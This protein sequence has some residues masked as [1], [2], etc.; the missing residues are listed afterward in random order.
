MPWQ[1]P[2]ALAERARP[3]GELAAGDQDLGQLRV[4]RVGA[5]QG[6]HD[7][8][9][10]VA[11]LHAD[12]PGLHLERPARV[13]RPIGRLVSAN[14]LVEHDPA[15]P[16]GQPRRVVEQLRPA[17]EGV[18]VPGEAVARAEVPARLAVQRLRPA[19]VRVADI[20]RSWAALRLQSSAN[21]S[22][23][24]RSIIAAAASIVPG[25]PQRSSFV[26]FPTLAAIS[27]VRRSAVSGDGWRSHAT[28][29]IPARPSE[30]RRW[31]RPGLRRDVRGDAGPVPR[32]GVDA[33]PRQPVERP[34][35]P[36]AAQVERQELV[37]RDLAVE[38]VGRPQALCV[39]RGLG[40][41]ADRR[42]R[43]ARPAGVPLRAGELLVQLGRPEG[44]R[45][46]VRPCARR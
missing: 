37:G 25:L 1:R 14:C 17:E 42:D 2:A 3:P 16:G 24:P 36:G 19:A 29:R 45:R 41:A 6:G 44:V 8:G 43:V 31:Q 15:E 20:D 27:R 26:S 40:V 22:S 4:L 34:D 18:G 10:A 9:R 32:R 12:R 35:H 5:G 39:E 21:R 13:R 7:P 28:S 38:R 30:E 23:P 46:R 11:P 33:G